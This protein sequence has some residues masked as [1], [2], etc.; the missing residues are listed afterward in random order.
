MDRTQELRLA[1]GKFGAQ[2]VDDA[3]ACGAQKHCSGKKNP[4]LVDAGVRHLKGGG[5]ADRSLHYSNL[6]AEF[7]RELSTAGAPPPEKYRVG[8]PCP[9]R[10]GTQ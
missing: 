2:G 7:G 8:S 3:R 6:E 1:F 10:R 9:T 4:T 5:C